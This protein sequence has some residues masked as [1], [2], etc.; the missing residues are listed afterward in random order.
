LT[1]TDGEVRLKSHRLENLKN[2]EKPLVIH[3]RY[4]LDNLVTLADDEV[5][6]RLPAC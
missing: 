1:Y 3:Y 2:H 6:C 5:L 4:R